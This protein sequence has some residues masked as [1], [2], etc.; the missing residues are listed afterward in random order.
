MCIKLGQHF[1]INKPLLQEVWTLFRQLPL[2]GPGMGKST[3]AFWGS[4]GWNPIAF[5]NKMFCGLVSQ[6]I[7]KVG[8]KVW[9]SN[10]SFLGERLRV[11]SSFPIVGLHSEDG[12]YLSLSYLLKYGT[13]PRPQRVCRS[14]LSPFVFREHCSVCSH[15]SGVSSVE[16]GWFQ[17]PPYITILSWKTHVF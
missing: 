12:V 14:P 7:L 8:C 3:W 16:R 2:V 4:L 11:G 5:Q 6:V 15:R 10:S 13:P 17:D 9:G 1:K